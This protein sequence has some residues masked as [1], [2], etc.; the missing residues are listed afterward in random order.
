MIEFANTIQDSPH[1]PWLIG[2]DFNEVLKA[3][4]KFGGNSINNTRAT[5]F[6]D[7]INLFSLIDHGFKGSKFIWANKIYSNINSIALERLD[8]WLSNKVWIHFFF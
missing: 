1:I 8:R 4:E 6:W 7:C 3:F 2:R 5:A